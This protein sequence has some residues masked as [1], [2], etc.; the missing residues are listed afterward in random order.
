ME[1]SEEMIVVNLLTVYDKSDKST[2]SD[3]ELKTLIE[4]LEL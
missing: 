4:N 3:N 2:L 1:V